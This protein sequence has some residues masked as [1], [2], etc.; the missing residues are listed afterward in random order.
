MAGHERGSRRDCFEN[1]LREIRQNMIHVKGIK[2]KKVASRPTHPY[3]R[4]IQS[5]IESDFS[6]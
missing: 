1:N 3:C 4:W 6:P 2:A 5:L